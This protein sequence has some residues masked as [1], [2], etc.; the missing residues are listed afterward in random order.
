MLFLPLLLL[1]LRVRIG[2]IR[3]FH[4]KAAHMVKNVRNCSL[5]LLLFY[6]GLYPC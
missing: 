6:Y 2:V 4:N 1:V 5:A 3:I